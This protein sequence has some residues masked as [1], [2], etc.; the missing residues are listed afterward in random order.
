[1]H[2]IPGVLSGILGVIYA[3]F[4]SKN[5][6]GDSL[7]EFFHHLKDG[8]TPGQQAL[9][10]LPGLILS[11]LSEIIGGTMAGLVLKSKLFYKPNL[12]FTD[13]EFWDLE[14]IE[15]SDGYDELKKEDDYFSDNNKKISDK[16]FTE[17]IL[18]GNSNNSEKGN[19]PKIN[20][21]S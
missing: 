6:Y 16:D 17:V 3:A 2:G 1:M 4:A 14:G 13:R 21:V 15:V 19:I 11:L 9:Y 8:R 10:Q 20:I 5:R 18:T 7:E 12:L